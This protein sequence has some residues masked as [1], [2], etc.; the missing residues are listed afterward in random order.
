MERNWEEPP[1]DRTQNAEYRTQNAIWRAERA[2]TGFD[3]PYLAYSLTP[4]CHVRGCARVRS[5]VRPAST[6]ASNMFS[7][8]ANTWPRAKRA[9]TST[10][11]IV[12]DPSSNVLRS[13]SNCRAQ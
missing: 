1:Q 12:P 10:F 13:S 8:D 2:F 9:E 6:S 3:T 7:T 5:G 11:V 4:A